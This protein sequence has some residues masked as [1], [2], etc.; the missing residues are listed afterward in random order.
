MH[1]ALVAGGRLNHWET[2]VQYHLLHAVAMVA[3]AAGRHRA[4][5]VTLACW[6]GGIAFFSGSLYGLACS[7]VRWLG[8]ITPLGGMLFIAGWLWLSIRPPAGGE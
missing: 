6:A 2:A 7:G 3:L 4:S 1:E 5:S 8:A